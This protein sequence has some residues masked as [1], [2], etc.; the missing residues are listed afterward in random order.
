MRF[1]NRVVVSVFAS[2]AVLL[3]PAL[4]FAHARLLRSEPAAMSR[5]GVPPSVLR[6]WF[7]E[8]PELRFSTIDLADS[9]GTAIPLGSVAVGDS[10]SLVV[11]LAK[12]LSAGRYSVAWRTAAADGH[13]TSGRFTFIVAPAADP[14]AAPTPPAAPDSN[15]ARPIPPGRRA[16]APIEPGGPSGFSLPV[17]WAE[18]VA[19][20][21][22]IGAV[23]FRLFVL[24]G[25]EF[26][27]H[28]LNEASDRARRLAI[29][30]L[31]LFLVSSLTRLIAESEL[32]SGVARSTAMMSTIRDTR[33]GHGW[34]FAATGGIIAI[35]G[36]FVA[37]ATRTAWIVAGLGAV[38][39]CVGEAMT[40]HAAAMDR[41]APLAVATD[42]AHFLS[43]G[44]WLGG[45]TCVVLCGLPTLRAFDE[46][47]RVLSG[48]RLVRS[49]HRIA[50]ECVL[51]TILTAGIA[52][53]LRLGALSDLWTTPYGLA[54]L[55]KLIVVL[56]VLAFGLYHWRTA[57]VRDWAN[58]TAK[59]FRLSAT[60]ELL[61][62]AIV[63]A[64]T[65]VL[66][67]TAL[68][69]SP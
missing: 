44:G 37:R 34:M 66:I 45:L 24:P 61:A 29:A 3:T 56:V 30:V 2:L 69:T 13:S 16:N 39:I 51:L 40:G 43:A 64:L 4:L 1:R 8:R 14:V 58:T 65:T 48:A 12:A 18:L 57:V 67:S 27:V 28:E 35:V 19:V 6:L 41:H 31:M 32:M 55:R 50:M 46:R 49:Y 21:V 25:A 54:L 47:N 22:L 53:W 38:A 17:R 11:P 60:A 23:V 5:L 9:A 26:P 68:P 7:S 36:L 59:R 62:G 15:M 52:A 63:I 42:V 33:W 20:M 10:M